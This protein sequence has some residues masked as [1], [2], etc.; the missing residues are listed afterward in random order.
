MSDLPF[1]PPA[2]LDPGLA[3]AFRAALDREGK[4]GRALDALGPVAGRDV[5]I[6]DG[7]PEEIA[8]WAATGARVVPVEGLATPSGTALAAASADAVVSAWSGFR[9]VDPA[10][11][12]AADRLLR[13]AGRLL[14]VHDYGR[15]DVSRLRGDLPEYG[16][17]S[18]RNGPF[19]T[20]GFRVRVVHCFWTFETV[21]EAGA[22]LGGL[23]GA[24]GTAF[25][26]GLRRPRLSWNVAIYHRTRGGRQD[27]ERS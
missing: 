26:L 2:D 15:D 8:R 19:L 25:G 9:G 11:L 18:K 20:N 5:V 13:P 17:W 1:T 12:A 10:D 14:V 16:P 7:G 6:D 23:F 27:E 22:V 24:T 3:V 4:I 21:E